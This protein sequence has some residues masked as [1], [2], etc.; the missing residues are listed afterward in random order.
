MLIFRDFVITQGCGS[1]SIP[2]I[3]HVVPLKCNL[4]GQE[5]YLML[6]W[7]FIFLLQQSLI[8]HCLFLQ[9]TT[10]TLKVLLLCLSPKIL[11]ILALYLVSPNLFGLY[12]ISTCGMSRVG[13][14]LT[15]IGC[16]LG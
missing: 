1:Y 4:S 13:I 5:S 12:D 15:S 2:I 7:S 8:D 11:L 3:S 9:H 10:R 14:R 6:C 16:I